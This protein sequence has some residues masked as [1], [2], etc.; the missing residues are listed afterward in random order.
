M[1][2][3]GIAH[4]NGLVLVGHDD[5]LITQRSE[6]PHVDLDLHRYA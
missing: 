5:V 2:L 6:R 4:G 1:R 3:C